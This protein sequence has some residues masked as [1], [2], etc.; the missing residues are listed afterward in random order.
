VIDAFTEDV[1]AIAS[2][3]AILKHTKLYQL[4]STFW[5]TSGIAKKYF[6]NEE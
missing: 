5:S 6:D 4:R 3:V 2:E 1:G